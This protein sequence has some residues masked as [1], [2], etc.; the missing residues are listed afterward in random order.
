MIF[1]DDEIDKKKIK[2]FE[3]L[4]RSLRLSLVKTSY[5]R[6]DINAILV[7]IYE[8]GAS[9]L[10]L[11]SDDYAKIKYQR[12]L[13]PISHRILTDSEV[14]GFIKEIYGENATAEINIGKDIN[15][16]HAIN[17][18]DG[19]VIR[20]RVNAIGVFSAGGDG[21]Q[22]TIRTIQSKPLKLSVLKLEDEIWN[23]FV[24]DQ[25]LIIVTGP[26]GSGKTTLMSSCIREILED[27]YGSKKIVTYEQPI[28]FVYNEIDKG[29]NIITQT[30][31]PKNIKTFDE[32]VESSMRRAPNIIFIGESRDKATIMNSILASQTGHLVYTTAHTNSAAETVRRMIN[33]F[34][35]EE[36]N[37][38][39]YDLIDSL[40][41]IVAQ[42][43]IRDV[44]NKSIAIREYLVFTSQIKDH[45]KK[46]DANNVSAEIKRIVIAKKQ[47]L[48]DDAL[49]KYKAGL[50]SIDVLRALEKDYRS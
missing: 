4:S 14:K 27:K 45:L 13:I 8:K 41:M 7:E 10:H 30:E 21:I 2:E 31:V 17:M 44:N 42:R 5:H 24:P 22:I 35:P 36:R 50:I 37:S 33:V 16:S 34:S 9:D 23:N 12:D 39:Q 15:T 32:A 1:M 11:Q 18:A 6:S 48:F 3:E 46:V 38:L 47:T 20:F 29:N 26:T 19:S 40:K 28:E 49:R 25:G 43:L